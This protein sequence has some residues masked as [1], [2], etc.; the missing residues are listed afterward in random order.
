MSSLAVA[1]LRREAHQGLVPVLPGLAG[2]FPDQGLR[3]G[4]TVAV[5]GSASLLLAVLAGPAA[6]GSW[7]AV[8]GLPQVGV[9]AAA[10]AGVVLERLVLVPAPGRRAAVVTAA[11]LEAFD[12]VVLP[13]DAVTRSEARRLQ[14]RARTDGAVLVA[15]G[16]WDGADLRLEVTAGR[17]EGLGEGHG[18]LRAWSVEVVAGGRG[19]AVR[20]RRGRLWLPDPDG[21]WAVPD[22][23]QP[24]AL[25]VV[26]EGVA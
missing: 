21:R 1:G 7:C 5:R 11:L 14:A 4:A 20:P 17:W 13:G 24:P 12:V 16:P 25:H 22:R 19:A 18:H 3:R 15:T 9:V 6:G 26:G 2:L 8:V 10:E 23:S